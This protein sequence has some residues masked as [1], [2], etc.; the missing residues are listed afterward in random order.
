MVISNAYLTIFSAGT[1]VGAASVYYFLKHLDKANAL[2][3]EEK[4][5]VRTLSNDFR[6]VKLLI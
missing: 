5:E 4:F 2:P 1:F 6:L 3:L